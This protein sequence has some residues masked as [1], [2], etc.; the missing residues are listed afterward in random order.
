[1]KQLFLVIALFA[2][3]F[4]HANIDPTLDKPG[5][6]TGVVF[7]KNLQ[8]PIPY[9]TVAV[10]TLSGEIITGGVTDDDGKFIIEEIPE[11]KSNVSIQYIGY[12]TYSTEIEISRGNRNI[13]LGNIE[14][15]EDIAALGEVTVV[16]ERST[17]QQK[18]DRKVINVG[19][20]LTTAGPTASDIM[21]NLPSVSVDQQT[22][23]I[24]LRGNQNV[25]VM[26]DGKLSNV[27]LHN[28]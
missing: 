13:D 12:K 10:K 19:K 6:I 22:G 7:D 3:V 21:N 15:E 9:V 26:V 11:G 17:I 2:C 14:L 8:Q 23:D 25:R 16:A 20:D 24:S 4:T 28:F 27:L 1:M 5:K 18:L